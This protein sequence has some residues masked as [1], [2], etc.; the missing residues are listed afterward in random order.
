M[1]IS[2]CTQPCHA[3]EYPVCAKCLVL[4]LQQPVFRSGRCDGEE[5][6]APTLTDPSGAKPG[7]KSRL[8]CL[9]TQH[10]PS[11]LPGV[12]L[13]WQGDRARQHP[14]VLD[15]FCR[16]AGAQTPAIKSWLLPG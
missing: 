6:S 16:Q 1:R 7:L 12:S 11:L 15:G 3:G 10:S 4:I 5:K 8:L 13:D 9:L 2:K 14:G